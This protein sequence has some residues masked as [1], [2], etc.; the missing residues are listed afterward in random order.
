MTINEFLESSNNKSIRFPKYYYQKIIS[1]G[2]LKV[3]LNFQSIMD[4]YIQY[5]RDYIVDIEL[6][7]EEMRKY[8]Y[9]P[10]VLSYTLYGTTAYWWSILLANQIHSISEFDFE[11]DNTIKVF[12]Q[13]GIT[14]FSNVLSVDKTFINENNS[15]YSKDKKALM[16]EIAKANAEEVMSSQ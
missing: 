3:S 12:S 16:Q 14:A 1:E 6:S 2:D 10:K 13:S 5:I 7:Q 9:N 15:E 8:R 11:R 4:R